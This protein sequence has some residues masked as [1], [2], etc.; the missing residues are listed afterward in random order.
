M[1]LRSHPL[2]ADCER[3]GRVT[4]ATDVHHLVARR[5]GG[6]DEESNLEALCHSCHSKRTASGE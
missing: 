1:F 5:A 6:G 2:C 3:Q 4:P